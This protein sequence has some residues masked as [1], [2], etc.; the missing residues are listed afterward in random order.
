[1]GPKRTGHI[2]RHKSDF[3]VIEHVINGWIPG[4]H[5]RKPPAEADDRR[6]RNKTDREETS[7][8]RRPA[9]HK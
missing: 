6:P 1:M 2:D 4:Y 3:D 9:R 8:P 5:D 7:H